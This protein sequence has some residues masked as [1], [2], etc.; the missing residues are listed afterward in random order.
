MS[1]NNTSE[2][3]PL[4][5][6][7]GADASTPM[8]DAVKALTAKVVALEASLARIEAKMGLSSKTSKSWDSS[9]AT[10]KRLINR[11]S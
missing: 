6:V 11:L 3:V 1:F 4:D 10:R 5:I 9:K 2:T 7:G 8:L